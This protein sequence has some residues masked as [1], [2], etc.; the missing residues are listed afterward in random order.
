VTEASETV[1]LDLTPS[2]PEDLPDSAKAVYK[3]LALEGPMTHRELVEYTDIPARTVRYAVKR[4][5]RADCLGERVNL[6]DSRQRFFFIQ[7]D[8]S[9]DTAGD[10]PTL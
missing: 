7:R 5:K 4:L 3:L 6:K 9:A 2:P 1:G 8:E 10:A